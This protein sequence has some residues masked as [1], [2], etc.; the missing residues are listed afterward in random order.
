MTILLSND[1]R[2]G[3]FD[4]ADQLNARLAAD[5]EKPMKLL[6]K[7]GYI[8][9][10]FEVKNTSTFVMNIKRATADLFQLQLRKNETFYSLQEVRDQ[11]LSSLLASKE[12]PSVD[13]LLILL[14]S[15]P[16]GTTGNLQDLLRCASKEDWVFSGKE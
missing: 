10:I 2:P 13:C 8:T 11:P 5:F 14:F 16:A 3:T 1:G 9:E 7:D 12:A 4:T 6:F 15:I